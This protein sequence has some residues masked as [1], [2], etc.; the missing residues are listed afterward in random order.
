MATPAVSAWTPSH[1]LST[2]AAPAR[3]TTIPIAV[4]AVGR[5]SRNAANANN[6]VNNGAVPLA[7]PATADDTWISA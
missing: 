3:P 7:T 4:R 6:A 5:S 1:T 2:T